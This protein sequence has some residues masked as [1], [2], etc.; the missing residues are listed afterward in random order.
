[1]KEIPPFLIR[2]SAA[3]KTGSTS[4]K[5][6]KGGGAGTGRSRGLQDQ[7]NA[8]V[9]QAGLQCW[10]LSGLRHVPVDCHCCGGNLPVVAPGPRLLHTWIFVGCFSAAPLLAA[11]RDDCRDV[12]PLDRIPAFNVSKSPVCEHKS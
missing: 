6:G 5:A 2:S 8:F 7:G 1:M 4:W 11:S 9:P 10:R 3:N 12:S